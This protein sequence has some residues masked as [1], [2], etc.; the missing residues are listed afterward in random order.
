M[1]L[2]FSCHKGHLIRSLSSV[3]CGHDAWGIRTSPSLH[4]PRPVRQ[5]LGSENDGPG[6]WV[7]PSSKW[8]FG[9]KSKWHSYRKERRQTPSLPDTVEERSDEQRK[10]KQYVVL[11]NWH[12]FV[13]LV[14]QE[15]KVTAKPGA[16]PHWHL[17]SH[18]EWYLA[19]S[20]RQTLAEGMIGCWNFFLKS[21]VV[22]S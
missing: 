5:L 10:K 22:S 6:V 19:S 16:H 11:L 1:D 2:Y 20:A 18:M 3:L 13:C 21:I 7:V 9:N 14:I 4:L 8:E 15:C 17:Y 12:S